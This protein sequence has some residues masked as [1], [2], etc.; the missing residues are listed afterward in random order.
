MPGDG[1]IT[2]YIVNYRQA[3]SYEPQG[4]IEYPWET[5]SIS[6]DTTL[7]VTDL[8]WDTLYEFSVTACRPGEGGEGKP[9]PA[10]WGATKCDGKFK[11]IS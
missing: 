7:V 8:H 5:I 1:P 9:S 3:I 2:E 10:V 6:G 4:V 11:L